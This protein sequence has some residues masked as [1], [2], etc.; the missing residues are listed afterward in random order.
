MPKSFI[1]LGTFLSYF[2]NPLISAVAW[3]LVHLSIHL[4]LSTSILLSK[5]RT[6]SSQSS[7]AAVK[8]WTEAWCS[9][10]RVTSLF[11]SSTHVAQSFGKAFWLIL[12]QKS[13]SP[14]DTF[15]S[16]CALQSWILYWKGPSLFVSLTV[17]SDICKALI[18]ATRKQRR[19]KPKGIKL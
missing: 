3:I 4:S 16:F 7:Q 11:C 14:T 2:K 9:Q 5:A 12:C 17:A 19:K 13:P 8:R 10:V 6:L 15:H 1:R 18:G